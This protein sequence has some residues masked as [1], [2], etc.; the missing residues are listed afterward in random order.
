[1]TRTPVLLWVGQAE[2]R[3]GSR[4]E[5]GWGELARPGTAVRDRPPS[6]SWCCCCL[7]STETEPRVSMLKWVPSFYLHLDRVSVISTLAQA[8]LLKPV[9]L[10]PQPPGTGTAGLFY[11][12]ISS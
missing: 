5:Q 10:P 3:A 9:T 12:M 6:S 8:A 11:P 2:S 1:M 4:S 7:S